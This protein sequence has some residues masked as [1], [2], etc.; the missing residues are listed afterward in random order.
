MSDI[1][2]RAVMG[3]NN[4][5]S[6]IEL[7]RPVFDN[8]LRQILKDLPVIA[9]DDEARQAKLMLDRALLDL[10]RIEEERKSKVDPLNA[11]V[12]EI[13]ATYHKWHNTDARRHGLWDKPVDILRTRLSDW[14]WKEEARRR[15]EAEAARKAA[16]EAERLAREAEAREK[17][18]AETAAAGVCDV[19]VAAATQEAD[20]AFSQF[21]RASRIAQRAERDTKV[22]IGGGLGKVSTL[23][24]RE[25]LTV[26]D[27]KAAIDEMSDDDGEIPAVIVDAIL[28]AARAY[29]KVC[30]RLPA[31]ISQEFD[32]SI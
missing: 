30:E 7:V 4:P 19:D 27:W 17:E 8:E 1:N 14:A 2:P 12:K 23:R 9:N 20:T 25:I 31:G 18:A 24:N 32:R 26:K 22:R 29:R 3:G 21:R 15:E 13:N 11:E 16:E 10:K 28:T 5:P 6:V